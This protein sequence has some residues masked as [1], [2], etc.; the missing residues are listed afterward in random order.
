MTP[1]PVLPVLVLS[2]HPWRKGEAS[3]REGKG[4]PI[5]GVYISLSLSIQYPFFYVSPLPYPALYNP[6]SFF[7]KPLFVSALSSFPCVSPLFSF[8]TTPP[9]NPQ[10]T[11]CILSQ[12]RHNTTQASSHSLHKSLIS[13]TRLF[14]GK[15]KLNQW[16]NILHL[17]DGDG[18]LKGCSWLG[19]GSSGTRNCRPH[20]RWFYLAVLHTNHN[21]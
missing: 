20:W 18:L 8:P 19:G 13:P 15:W 3:W 17:Q 16:K 2:L 5:I 10:I 6:C 14:S 11:H 7:P 12:S 9:H 21:K 4:N 1:R